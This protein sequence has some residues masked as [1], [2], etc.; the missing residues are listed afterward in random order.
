MRRP[1]ATALLLA[2]VVPLLGAR[3]L[4]AVARTQILLLEGALEEFRI[5]HGRYPTTAEGLAALTERPAYLWSGRV[6]VD[7]WG[8][9]FL[10]RSPGEHNADRFDLGSLGAD[11]SRGGDG[12]AADLGNWPG[13]FAALEQYEREEVVHFPFE[14]GLLTGGAVGLP[15]YLFGLLSAALGNRSWRSAW[16]GAPLA[17]AAALVL[18]GI[19]IAI[20]FP[21]VD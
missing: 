15:I 14:V 1:I 5:D 8:R 19:L 3:T 9:P 6:P 7:P 13:G 18:A 10:Y 16:F 20:G 4:P 11:G 17:T 2:A 12:I 21:R